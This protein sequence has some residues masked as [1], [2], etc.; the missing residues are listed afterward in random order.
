MTPS[1]DEFEELL[2]EHEQSVHGPKRGGIWYVI[3][4][5]GWKAE[6]EDKEVPDPDVDPTEWFTPDYDAR[7]DE[8][9]DRANAKHRRHVAEELANL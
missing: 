9:H 7:F 3:C 2:T 5:C 6:W 1:A 4:K 8:C